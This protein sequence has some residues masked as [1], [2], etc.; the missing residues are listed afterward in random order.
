MLCASFVKEKQQAFF[1]E[2]GSAE[3]NV[4]MKKNLRPILE[5]LIVILG[6]AMY[7]FSVV[8]FVKPTGLITGGTTG[9]ALFANT[10]FGVNLSVCSF[11]LN[12]SLFEATKVGILTGPWSASIQ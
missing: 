8:A 12:A 10:T 4:P 2:K 1:Y 11:I 9:L 5:I 7:A 6:N 3:E